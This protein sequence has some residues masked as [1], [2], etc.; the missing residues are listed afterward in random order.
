MKKIAAILPNRFANPALK[1]LD[2]CRK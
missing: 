1:K 2:P